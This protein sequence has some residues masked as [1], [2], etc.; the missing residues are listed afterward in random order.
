M[1]IFLKHLTPLNDIRH[2]HL[3]VLF[4]NNE[5]GLMNLKCDQNGGTESVN[6]G[7]LCIPYTRVIEFGN[8]C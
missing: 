6:Q 7:G 3:V 1:E 5:L 4:S 8:K 2:L